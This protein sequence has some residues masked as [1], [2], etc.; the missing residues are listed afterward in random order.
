MTTPRDSELDYSLDYDLNYA[1]VSGHGR[2]GTNWLL[3]LLDLSPQTFCRNE[4]SGIEGSPLKKLDHDRWVK[5]DDQRGLSEGWDEAV[6]W[7]AARMGERDRKITMPKNHMYQ[8]SRDL[9]LH[10]VVRGPKYRRALSSVLPSLRG[11][12][13]LPPSFVFNQKRLAQALPVL[14]LVSSPGWSDFVLHHRPGVR[15]FHIVR[16]PGGFLQSWTKRYRSKQDEETTHR[17]NRARL[18][19]IA[20]EQPEWAERFGDIAA[21]TTEESELWFWCHAAET[22]D[23]AGEKRAAYY[24]IVYE[25]LAS[26]AVPI[27][28][29][30]YEMCGLDWSEHIEQAVIAASQLS[31]S[32]AS[33]WQRE[34]SD[35]QVE[36]VMRILGQ[37]SLRD[38]WP[39]FER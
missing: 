25:E 1:L 22:I 21:M 18:E 11:G 39:A 38:L 34:L 8:I 27:V 2:S 30:C 13:W 26:D 23:R 19:D 3:E 17:N 33:K 10:R 12:E 4:P 20:R 6:R 5:R 32:I 14:K 24:R 7:T 28:R 16:H 29:H 31:E 15:L 35:Q 36:L 9:G 37:C